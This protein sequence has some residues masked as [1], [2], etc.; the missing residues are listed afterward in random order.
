MKTSIATV[1]HL[2]SLLGKAEDLRILCYSD[3][4]H[5]SLPNG[6]SQGVYIVFL[7]GKN[8]MVVPIVQQSKKICRVTKN[9]ESVGVRDIV[10][11]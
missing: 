3:A 6:A 2:I 8:N 11:E 4:T 7:L 9:K 1:I 10:L 5:A